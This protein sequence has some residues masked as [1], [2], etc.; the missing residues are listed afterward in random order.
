MNWTTP[1]ID[2]L[3]VNEAVQL[4][5]YYSNELCT[6]TRGSL[7]TGRY[8]F[9]IGFQNGT[10]ENN[11]YSQLGL[12]EVTIAQELQSA[13]Y[14]TYLVGKWDVGFETP[15][16][17]PTKRGFDYFYGYYNGVVSYPSSV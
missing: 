6:P 17:V 9:R 16:H 14:K 13:G 4:T 10:N 3:F 8:A 12:D 15:M 7:L 11:L 2:S 5:N 1:H